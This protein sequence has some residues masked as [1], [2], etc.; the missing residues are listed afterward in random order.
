MLDLTVFHLLPPHLHHPPSHAQSTP[1]ASYSPSS[2]LSSS[3]L[4]PVFFISWSSCFLHF[5][6]HVLPLY[7]NPSCSLFSFS[8]KIFSS[9]NLPTYFAGIFFPSFLSRIPSLFCLFSLASFFLHSPIL[10]FHIR[11]FPF[12]FISVYFLS[13]LMSPLSP[14]PHLALLF[15]ACPTLTRLGSPPHHTHTPSVSQLIPFFSQHTKVSQLSRLL[16][17][18]SNSFLFTSF[19]CSL[20]Y[21][22]PILHLSFSAVVSPFLP[23]F[24]SSLPS[25]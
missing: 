6:H 18:L 2:S 23:R 16:L 3:F 4:S 8:H 15:P 10:A 20:S 22:I 14:V 17:S 19:S 11:S 5:I 25:E 12:F 7:V 13:N 21:Y 1:S 24:R 9:L